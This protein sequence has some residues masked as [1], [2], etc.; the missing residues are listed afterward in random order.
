[1]TTFR[2]DGVRGQREG[3]VPLPVPYQD[4][5]EAMKRTRPICH[6][7]SP[8]TPVYGGWSVESDMTITCNKCGG[9][10]DKKEPA[11]K[12]KKPPRSRKGWALLVGG[13]WWG[14]SKPEAGAYPIM[15]VPLSV[16]RAEQAVIA[17]AWQPYDA[18][19]MMRVLY[20]M[21]DVKEGKE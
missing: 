7:P 10:R 14:V 1:M 9:T 3:E 2:T 20:H 16:H 19:Q 18:E 17:Q 12:T 21:Q 11:V 13:K 6:C 15:V 5:E 4:G 8:A